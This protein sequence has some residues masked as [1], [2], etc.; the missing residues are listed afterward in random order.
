MLAETMLKMVRRSLIERERPSRGERGGDRLDEKREGGTGT[1]IEPPRP[2][3]GIE[4]S[5][6]LTTG[7]AVDC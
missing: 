4:V 6:C 5:S 1:E 2:Q 7:G 3:Y